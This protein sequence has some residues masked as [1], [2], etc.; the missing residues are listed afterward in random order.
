MIISIGKALVGNDSRNAEFLDPGCRG[1][2]ATGAE[3]W[4]GGRLL[5]SRAGTAV[6]ANGE[7]ADAATRENIAKFMQGFVAFVQQRRER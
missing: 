2:H 7:I 5:V 3:L 6:D 1:A 4:S